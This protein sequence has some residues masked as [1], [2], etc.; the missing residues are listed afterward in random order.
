[1]Y[2]YGDYIN[3]SNVSAIR[4][5]FIEESKERKKI[6]INNLFTGFALDKHNLVQDRKNWSRDLR[7]AFYKIKK[8]VDSDETNTNDS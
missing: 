2:F 8:E 6:F 7:K 1:M 4:Q 5:K 3:L